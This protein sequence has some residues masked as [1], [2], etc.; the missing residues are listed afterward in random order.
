MALMSSV[1]GNAAGAAEA[2]GTR[3]DCRYFL[4]YSGVKLPFN[5]VSPIPQEGLGHRNTFIRAFY[6]AA[7][8]LAGFEKVVYGEVELTH[9]YFYHASG[10]LRSAV[11]AM[12]EEEPS[13]LLFDEAGR[14]VGGG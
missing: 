9:S 6:D 1:S 11:V 2:D 3:R 13:E 14:L 7:G 5:L 10:A 8:R 4:S 12:L